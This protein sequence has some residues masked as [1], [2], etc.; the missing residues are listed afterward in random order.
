MKKILIILFCLLSINKLSAQKKETKIVLTSF[1]E[2][3]IKDLE[4]GPL[5]KPLFNEYNFKK[6]ISK[7]ITAYIAG[8]NQYD[9]KDGSQFTVVST[10]TYTLFSII[11]GK[12]IKIKSKWYDEPPNILNFENQFYK[13]EIICGIPEDYGKYHMTIIRKS[14]LKSQLFKLFYWRYEYGE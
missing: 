1:T 7:Y 5:S 12:Q 11:D 6:G 8:E 9:Y 3:A 14:D 13:I 4:I 2:K 10:H